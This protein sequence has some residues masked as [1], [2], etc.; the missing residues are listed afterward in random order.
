M[1]GN[2]C[3]C[4]RYRYLQQRDQYPSVRRISRCLHGN[5]SLFQILLIGNPSCRSPAF[6]SVHSTGCFEA[7][8]RSS[9]SFSRNPRPWIVTFSEVLC[10]RAMS[11]ITFLVAEVRWFNSFRVPI[12][13][14][15]ESI[16]S[17]LCVR[18][19]LMDQNKSSRPS[20]YLYWCRVTVGCIT[21]NC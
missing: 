8:N 12:S 10:Y 19:C 4:H 15:I 11:T 3:E 9:V 21:V 6:N 17:F 2:G 16:Q 13:P 5:R 7:W 1:Q 20:N 18:T 14:H